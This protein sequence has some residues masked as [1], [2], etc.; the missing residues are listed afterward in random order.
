MHWPTPNDVL[1]MRGYLA[2][3]GQEHHVWA[4]SSCITLTPACWKM[5]CLFGHIA[6]H[7]PWC[8]WSQIFLN[9]VIIGRVGFLGE[10]E[11][12]VYSLSIND[13]AGKSLGINPV[14][15]PRLK[16]LYY[17]GGQCW[18]C[19]AVL[20]SQKAPCAERSNPGSENTHTAFIS[21]LP[22]IQVIWHIC[23]LN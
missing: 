23:L 19:K 16:E 1:M 21:T 8:W 4:I 22:F 15:S 7:P 10:I 5:S 20:W 6:G 2:W 12:I 3:K 17:T 13:L 18:I 9:P 11:V 14:P